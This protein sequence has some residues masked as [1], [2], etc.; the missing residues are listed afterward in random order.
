MA[1][2]Y[3]GT[4]ALLSQLLD[5]NAAAHV[6][7]VTCP[8]ALVGQS[9]RAALRCLLKQRGMITLAAQRQGQ[10]FTNPRGEFL[11][12]A[13]DGLFVIARE[14]PDDLHLVRADS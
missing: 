7:R 14:Y 11:L 4:A 2:L 12:Q 1:A 8:A 6:Y 3:H 9:F 13:G 10:L 5:A